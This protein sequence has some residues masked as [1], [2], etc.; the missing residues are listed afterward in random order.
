[1]QTDQCQ[2]NSNCHSH[3]LPVLTLLPLPPVLS[4]SLAASMC[5][6][7]AASQAACT[8][9]ARHT[10]ATT[11][12]ASVTTAC[13]CTRSSGTACTQ[14]SSCHAA[15]T[16]ASRYTPALDTQ[17]VAAFFRSAVVTI[18]VNTAAILLTQQISRISSRLHSHLSCQ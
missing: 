11:W 12:R 7:W 1:V 10:A 18:V 9:A 4:S 16:G 17:G 5:T 15:Q 8:S 14:T 2:S 13:P 6:W 3:P